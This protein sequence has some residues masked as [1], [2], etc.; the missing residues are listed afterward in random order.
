M[1]SPGDER[2]SVYDGNGHSMERARAKVHS[3]IVWSI[4][5]DAFNL[6]SKHSPS[7]PQNKSLMDFFEEKVKEK[8][9]DEES[10]KLVLYMARIWGDFVGDSIEKQSLKVW[11]QSPRNL[12]H[13]C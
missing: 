1:Y 2:P 10:Q 8:G 4:I 11:H 6:S 3:D 5:D 7:I 12:Y 13:S 9:L